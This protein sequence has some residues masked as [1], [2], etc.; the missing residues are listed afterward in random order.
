MPASRV[1]PAEKPLP[2]S[3]RRNLRSV[4]M[5]ALLFLMVVIWGGNY[6]LIKATLAELPPR[7]FNALRLTFASAAFLLM[8]AW[9][10]SRGPSRPAEVRQPRHVPRR[11]AARDHQADRRRLGPH[12]RDRAQERELLMMSLMCGSTCA[13]LTRDTI[14]DA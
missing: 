10:W 3:T 4:A 9:M 13:T 14:A 1:T 8:L 11:S 2:V 7:P 6:S 12:S 5:D